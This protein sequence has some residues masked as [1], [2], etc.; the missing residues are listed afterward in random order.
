MMKGKVIAAWNQQVRISF[1]VTTE[2]RL[3]AKSKS[4]YVP[5]PP[6][7]HHVA[8]HICFHDIDFVVIHPGGQVELVEIKGG[9][10]TQTAAWKLKRSLLEASLLREHPEI[11]YSVVS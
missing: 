9:K 1:D 3:I 11:K 5:P 7:G 8:H 10:A 2:G 6:A 4:L